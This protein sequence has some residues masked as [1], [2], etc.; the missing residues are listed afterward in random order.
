MN[1]QIE[2]AFSRKKLVLLFVLALAFIIMGV[3][4][5]I[6]PVNFTSPIQ[7]NP[8]IIQIVGIISVLFFGIASLFIVPKLWGSPVGLLINEQGIT[9][10]TVAGSSHHI[11]WSDV[12]GFR[13][14]KIRQSKIILVH[15]KNPEKYI[16]A[17]TNYF[18]RQIM[19]SNYNLYGSPLSISVN[20]LKIKHK[21]L[22]KA[23]E[24]EWQ[25]QTTQ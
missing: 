25:N 20:A 5:I 22:L 3:Q 24:K 12:V 10:N 19:R 14:I 9:N 13:S 21:P 8:Q 2:I 1:R 18:K 23:L 17:E 15:T 16:E 11:P 4:F 6:S 7:Q